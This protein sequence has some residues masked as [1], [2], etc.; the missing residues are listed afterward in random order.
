MYKYFNRSFLFSVFILTHFISI[1]FRL[2]F[3]IPI[4]HVYGL[5]LTNFS[6]I[7]ISYV[8][9]SCLITLLASIFLSYWSLCLIALNYFKKV[10]LELEVVYY[11]IICI[12]ICIYPYLSLLVL[13]CIYNIRLYIILL[14]TFCILLH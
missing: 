13:Y 2:L 14:R 1:S 3:S 9:V 10:H 5:V 4:R 7:S 12:I 8:V 6:Y 11:A